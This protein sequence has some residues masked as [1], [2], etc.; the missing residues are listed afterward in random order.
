M[1]TNLGTW[2]GST[3]S[4]QGF[5]VVDILE[6]GNFVSAQVEKVVADRRPVGLADKLA[7]VGEDTACTVVH[8]Q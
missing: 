2:T 8:L 1:R 4:W 6:W 5:E 7:A 3:G